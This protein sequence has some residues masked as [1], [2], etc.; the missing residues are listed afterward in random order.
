[1]HFVFFIF[2]LTFGAWL[3]V[4][5]QLIAWK[6]SSPTL[7][8]VGPKPPHSL[9]LVQWLVG[10]D[11]SGRVRLMHSLPQQFFETINVELRHVELVS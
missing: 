11:I 5:V 10:R 8:L 6:I 3:S 1:M 2:L 9:D 7:T 4:P